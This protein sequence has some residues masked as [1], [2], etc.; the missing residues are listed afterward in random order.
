L[1]AVESS[2]CCLKRPGRQRKSLKTKCCGP[3]PCLEERAFDVTRY[4]RGAFRIVDVE[5][6]GGVMLEKP[7]EVFGEDRSANTC[8]K[9]RRAA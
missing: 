3:S 6:L 1:T 4:Y 5:Q 2:H 9:S 8:I 7:A